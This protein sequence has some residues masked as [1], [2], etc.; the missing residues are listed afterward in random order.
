MRGYLPLLALPAL[1]PLLLLTGGIES[2]VRFVYYPIVLLLTP[3]SNSNPLL[4][5]SLVFT[6]LYA[7]MPS[8]KGLWEYPAYDVAVNVLGFLSMGITAGYISD[9]IRKE[10]A[11]M[12]RSSDTYHGLT[13][14]LNL[15][16]LNLQSELESV[17]E[18][19]GKLKDM[20]KNKTQFLASISHEIRSPLSS[21]RSFSE[22]L[23][24]YDD[25]DPET[26][27]EFLGIISKESRRLTH[28]TNEILDIVR[29]DSG[30][31]QWHMDT[32]GISDV[33]QAGVK[34]VVPLVKEKGLSIKAS[35]PPR[36]PPVWAD[37]NRLLQVMLNLLS[38][39][40]KFTSDG[41]ITVKARDMGDNI[42]VSVADTGEG[43]YPEE[44][45]KVFDEFYRI[46]DDL[47]GRPA[48]S[49]LGLSI[50]KK[51]VEAH[52]GRIWVE[53]RMGKGSTFNFTVPKGGEIGETAQSPRYARQHT[54]IVGGR[55]VMILDDSTAMRQI[56]R[57]AIEE[58]GYITMG[59]GDVGKALEMVKATKPDAVLLGYL[60]HEDHLGELRTIFSVQWIPFYL[61]VIINDE[62]LGAQLAVNG[63]ITT[64]INEQQV[65]TALQR[66]LHKVKGKV[67]IISDRPGEARNLQLSAGTGGYETSVVP[68][69]ASAD[70]RTAPPPPPDLII[71]GTSSKDRAYG[72]ILALRGNKATRDIPLVLTLG[73]SATDIE[74]VGLGSS[75]YGNGLAELFAELEGGG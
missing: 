72:T 61:A 46:G 66:V 6:L 68:D 75:S 48:G 38:N 3:F 57:D 30:Q 2:P 10:S 50:S 53:S 62:E 36:L 27:K 64:P 18:A 51:I 14:A 15:K 34:T 16:I 45:E 23:H 39:A 55:H 11:S 63:Y 1:I 25:I 65:H 41:K 59:A 20:N 37:R 13:Q 22:I 40:V 35:V 73:I 70:I 7:T 28:L 60:D 24:N 44:R 31:T 12:D 26:N 74:C 42:Q 32:V 17:T 43:I 58:E 71:I 52:G 29:I 9:R 54:D 19:Y 4:L 8:M 21:I 33:I 67:L 69:V 5:S 49:G 47:T 56:L